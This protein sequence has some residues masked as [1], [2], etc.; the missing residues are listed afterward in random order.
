MLPST[1][2]RADED[3]IRVALPEQVPRNLETTRQLVE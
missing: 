1:E 2:R 3:P